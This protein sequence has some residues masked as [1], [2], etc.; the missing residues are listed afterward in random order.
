MTKHACIACRQ[1]ADFVGRRKK[2]KKKSK[3]K[4]GINAKKNIFKGIKKTKLL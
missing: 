3:K 4:Q 1:E 2:S